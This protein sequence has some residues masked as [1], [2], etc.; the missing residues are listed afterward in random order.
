M[1]VLACLALLLIATTSAA[2]DG[3]KLY[4]YVD[5]NG[6]V[7]FTDQPPTRGARPYVLDN[8]RPAIAKKRWDDAAAV[9]VIRKAT[10]FA[11]HWTLPSPGQTY[12]SA[13]EGLLVVVSVMP[14]LAKG[15]GINFQV[16]GKTQN[17]RPID[18]IKTTLHGIGAGRHELVAILLN[19]GGVELARTMP[20]SIE[21]KAAPRKK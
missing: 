9:E 2:A 16:D 21:I 5:P 19:R 12:N 4:R 6:T 3:G 13:G 20:I 18:D 10:R 17:P 1:R 11:V 14:G 7:H 8:S 15:L